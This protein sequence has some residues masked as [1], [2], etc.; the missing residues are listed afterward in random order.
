M[1]PSTSTATG[2]VLVLSATLASAVFSI[3]SDDPFPSRDF[4]IDFAGDPNTLQM[5]RG[6]EFWGRLGMNDKL[7]AYIESDGKCKPIR[8][9]ASIQ[10]V[11]H[12]LTGIPVN[13]AKTLMAR[14]VFAATT[15]DNNCFDDF[16]GCDVFTTTQ[17]LEFNH[18]HGAAITRA[19]ANLHRLLTAQIDAYDVAMTLW[20]EKYVSLARF[21]LS[22]LMTE[23]KRPP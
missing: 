1:I 4:C 8:L 12:V 19:L 13:W 18:E 16:S 2:V 9:N 22:T 17:C 20:E 23:G 11:P 15:F 3:G 6:V 7:Q 21:M 14:D 5:T 10:S